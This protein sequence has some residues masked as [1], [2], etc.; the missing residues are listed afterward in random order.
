MSGPEEIAPHSEA[1]VVYELTP[2]YMDPG[3]FVIRSSVHADGT[4]TV[5][6]VRGLI[7]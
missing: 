4:E 7:D 5:I 6:E 2:C 3:P 1:V